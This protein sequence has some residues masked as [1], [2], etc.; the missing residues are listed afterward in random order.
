M[1]LFYLKSN[2]VSPVCKTDFGKLGIQDRIKGIRKH[3]K[4]RICTGRNAVF[5]K[6]LM[7]L[8]GQEGYCSC[9]HLA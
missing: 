8:P 4:F 9:L 7:H 5:S 6:L 3:I 1:S 2:S